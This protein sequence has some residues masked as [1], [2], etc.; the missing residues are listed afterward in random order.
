MSWTKLGLTIAYRLLL[1]VQWGIGALSLLFG[2]SELSDILFG[3]FGIWSKF[4]VPLLFAVGWVV[5]FQFVFVSP[6]KQKLNELDL[7]GE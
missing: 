7:T 5:F 3:E 4:Y 6:I 2:L 1:S